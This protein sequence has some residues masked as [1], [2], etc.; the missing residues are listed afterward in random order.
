MPKEKKEKKVSMYDP[1]VGA[2]R[3]IPI[4]RARELVKEAG[5]IKELLEAEEDD[6]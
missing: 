5:N 4:S 2:Y 3:E 1:T 6:E